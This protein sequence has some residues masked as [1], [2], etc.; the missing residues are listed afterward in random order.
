VPLG[1]C[2]EPTRQLSDARVSP[3]FGFPTSRRLATE[4]EAAYS[5][6]E[7]IMLRNGVSGDSSREDIILGR[8]LNEP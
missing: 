2:V 1:A 7:Y 5:L 8:S 4:L 6:Y 3:W